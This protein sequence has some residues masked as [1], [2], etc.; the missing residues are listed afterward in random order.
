MRRSNILR[1]F[2]LGV[3]LVV[4]AATTAPASASTVNVT[5]FAFTHSCCGDD[6][7]SESKSGGGSNNFIISSVGPTMESLAEGGI[8]VAGSWYVYAHA[9]ATATPV[10]RG[11]YAD[12][13]IDVDVRDQVT[14]IVPPYIDGGQVQF[15]QHFFVKGTTTASGTAPGRGEAYAGYRILV[16]NSQVA[17][18]SE[19]LWSDTGYLETM[20]RGEVTWTVEVA[21][22]VPFD[23]RILISAYAAA[24]GIEEFGGGT[25]KSDFGSTFVWGEATDVVHVTTGQPIP[26]EDFHLY[27]ADGFDWAHPPAIVPEPAALSLLGLAGFSLLFRRASRPT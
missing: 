22:N 3:V 20:P 1:L 9:Q 23:L 13:G 12:G 14:P 6:T 18:G 8:S 5:G 16:N 7:W 4:V 17:T 2:G 11:A 27:G 21:P 25:S 15:T 10:R 26:A 24:Y 19:T